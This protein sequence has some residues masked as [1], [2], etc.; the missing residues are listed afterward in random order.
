MKYKFLI[1]T[2]LCITIVSCQNT[3]NNGINQQSVESANKSDTLLD[4][5]IDL[6]KDYKIVARHGVDYLDLNFVPIDTTNDKAPTADIMFGNNVAC[7]ESLYENDILRDTFPST[8][9]GNQ[10]NWIRYKVDSVYYAEAFRSEECCASI[11]AFHESQ[12]D[13]FITIFKTLK[14][15]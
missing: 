13:S 14:R 6:P 3:K 9:L 4:Y 2:I 5:D 15:K 10:V 11:D 12:I 8:L 7:R 1:V